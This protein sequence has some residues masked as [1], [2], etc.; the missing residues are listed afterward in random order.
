MTGITSEDPLDHD[1][2]GIWQQGFEQGYQQGYED[3]A[4]DAWA[5]IDTH[6]EAKK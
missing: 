3:G 1:P 6:E 4:A 2:E 5:T